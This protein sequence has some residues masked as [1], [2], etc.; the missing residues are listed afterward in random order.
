MSI[1]IQWEEPPGRAYSPRPDKYEAVKAA[2]KANPGRSAVV[3]HGKSANTSWWKDQGFEATSRQQEDGTVKTYACWPVGK[4]PEDTTPVGRNPRRSAATTRQNAERRTAGA[5]P[6]G[7]DQPVPT[8]VKPNPRAI[9]VPRA[10]RK[11]PEKKPA[12]AAKAPA[13][14]A[15]EPQ[16]QA[17]AA[18]APAEAENR[19]VVPLVSQH[20]RRYRN[21]IVQKDPHGA[22]AAGGET[23]GTCTECKKPNRTIGQQ[24][25]I[26]RTCRLNNAT[27]RAL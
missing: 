13:P 17:P 18:P 11:P 15:P 4:D 1:E 9:T 21:E 5:R 12:P 3:F 23:T 19:N 6:A 8:V 24:D 2:L 22:L 26:C 25:H 7:D 20:P 10:K 27:R 16:D 14:A